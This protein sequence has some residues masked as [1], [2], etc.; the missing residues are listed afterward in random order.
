MRRKQHLRLLPCLA[1]H[2]LQATTTGVSI[3]LHA[4]PRASSFVLEA[5]RGLARPKPL[6][7]HL[8]ALV[9]AGTSDSGC[10]LISLGS[11]EL[12]KEVT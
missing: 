9:A 12:S 4:V 2:F 8:F 6:A 5:L 7:S 10:A 3:M 1:I 11:N